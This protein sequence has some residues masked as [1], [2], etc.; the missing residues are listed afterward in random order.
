MLFFLL[1]N[2]VN[3]YHINSQTILDAVIKQQQVEIS[4]IVYMHDISLTPDICYG[5]NCPF[6]ETLKDEPKELFSCSYDRFFDRQSDAVKR[7]Y[8]CRSQHLMNEK[9]RCDTLN[10]LNAELLNSKFIED[11][12]TIDHRIYTENKEYEQFFSKLFVFVKEQRNSCQQESQKERSKKC[13]F[14]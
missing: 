6:P 14:C 7:H 5:Y 2:Y 9:Q 11:C 8:N 4:C 3:A 10:S 13:F 12:S 1:L